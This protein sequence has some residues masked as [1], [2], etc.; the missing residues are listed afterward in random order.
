[1]VALKE[2]RPLSSLSRFSFL[3]IGNFQAEIATLDEGVQIVK[4]WWYYVGQALDFIDGM[5]DT[6]S[7]GLTARLREW[8]L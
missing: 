6:L 7:A 1:M 3:S 2:A 5:A 8:T 4:N